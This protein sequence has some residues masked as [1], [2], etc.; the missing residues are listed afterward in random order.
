MRSLL[1]GDI[2]DFPLKLRYTLRQFR[3]LYSHTLEVKLQLLRRVF[4]CIL[5][6]RE[7]GD[8]LSYILN[9]GSELSADESHLILQSVVLCLQSLDE[10]L[11]SGE[12]LFAG[13]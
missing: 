10:T 3:H 12:V 13:P 5:T 2:R 7:L 1:V 8:L 11:K 6:T 9:P 4:R